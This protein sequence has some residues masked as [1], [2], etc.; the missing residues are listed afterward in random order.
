MSGHEYIVERLLD[1]HINGMGEDHP[2]VRALLS[3]AASVI[4]GRDRS[5]AA[6]WQSIDTA[7]LDRS[8]LLW[9]RPI[10][11]DNLYSEC[12][13]IG[14]VSSHDVGKWWNGQRGELQ[15]LWHVTHWME[16]PTSP[17]HTVS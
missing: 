15:D 12:P 16:L 10:N 11:D 8:V 6:R 14:Q 9:W 17:R 3:E 2:N 1:R 4:K 5:M 13:V 7:P